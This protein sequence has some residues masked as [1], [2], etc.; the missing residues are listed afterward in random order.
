MI[1]VRNPSIEIRFVFQTGFYLRQIDLG[2]QAVYP[3]IDGR[4]ML[5]GG[6]V[7]AAGDASVVT[8]EALAAVYGVEAA[9]THAAG[10]PAVVV[11]GIRRN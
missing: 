5:R 6:A 2:Q 8:P 9:V 1:D 10:E 7:H 3:L 4:L 11:R